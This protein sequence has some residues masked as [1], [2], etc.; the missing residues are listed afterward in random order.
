MS[1]LNSSSGLPFVQPPTQSF[2]QSPVCPPV[3]PLVQSFVP[4]SVQSPAQPPV[5]SAV[6]P[7]VQFPLCSPVPLTYALLRLR[8]Y[9]VELLTYAACLALPFCL[10]LASGQQCHS[11][12]SLTLSQAAGA[13][14][15]SGANELKK[16]SPL[17]RWARWW[18]NSALW[19]PLQCYCN[20][21]CPD[22]SSLRILPSTLL[23][24][25]FQ[26]LPAKDSVAT[27]SASAASIAFHFKQPAAQHPADSPTCCLVCCLGLDDVFYSSPLGFPVARPMIISSETQVAFLRLSA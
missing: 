8:Q 10:Y 22:A 24:Q 1:M 17:L 2:V 15:D 27:S 26:E 20:S 14:R 12:L 18:R 4:S 7:Q 13:P 16:F 9:P 3:Q 11:Q 21:D 23:P 19:P 25:L 6:L 5:S